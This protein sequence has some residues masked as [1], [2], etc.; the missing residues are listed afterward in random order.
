M[1]RIGRLAT[2]S[3][4]PLLLFA[5]GCAFTDAKVNVGYTE[6]LA[7]RGPLSTVPAR[8]VEIGPIEDKRP[9]TD[10]IG[11]KRNGF[12]QKTAKIETEKPVAEIVREALAAEL[13]KNGHQIVSAPYDVHMSVEIAEFWFEMSIGFFTVD[14]VGTTSVVLKAQDPKT[15]I[16]LLDQTY[17]GYHKETAAGGLEG[18][19]GY[20]MNRALQQMMR[21]IAADFALVRALGKKPVSDAK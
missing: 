6:A 4:L 14:F 8:Q 5:A 19:W 11:Y 13:T 2:L 1:L 10:K 17:R 15:G 18:T 7:S 16:I 20:V 3:L 12:N 21:D 9:E